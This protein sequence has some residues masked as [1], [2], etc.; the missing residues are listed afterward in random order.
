MATVPTTPAQKIDLVG[1]IMAF[2]D[3]QMNES[4]VVDFFQHL[5]DTGLAW[6]LQGSDGR[7]A[8]RL[9]EAG[10]CTARA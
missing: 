4:E 7:M 1:S 9:I 10:H 2:E 3:G 5:I 6:T 8:T